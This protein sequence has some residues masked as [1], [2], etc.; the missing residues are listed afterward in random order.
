METRIGSEGDRAVRLCSSGFNCAESVLTVLSRRMKKMG[1]NCEGVVPCAATG[2][3]AGIGRNGG[4]CGALSGVVLALGLAAG[5]CRAEDF[6]TKYKVYELVEG[7]FEDFERRFG[8]DCC[9]DLIGMDLRIKDGRLLL[10]KGTRLKQS[11]ITSIKNFWANQL[12]EG[13]LL[14]S[15]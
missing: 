8:S 13:N 2:F 5:R 12:L 15:L 3:G 4:T 10:T 9:R 7:L 6:E 14:V 11:S 1:R